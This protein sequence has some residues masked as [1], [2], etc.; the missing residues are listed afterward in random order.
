MHQHE[1]R[2]QSGTGNH[3]IP[4]PLVDLKFLNEFSAAAA[5][6]SNRRH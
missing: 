5:G 4:V 6:T 3:G 1:G 2:K